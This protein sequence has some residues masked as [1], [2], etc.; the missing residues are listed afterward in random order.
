[1]ERYR[2]SVMLCGGTGCIAGGSL[3][4]K[5]ALDE[6][7]KNRGLEDEINVVLTGCNG[8]CA[9]GPVMTVY[10]EDIFYEK[11][12]VDDVPLI[13]EEHFIKG[14]PVQKLM[15]KE[16]VKK[17]TI[18]LMKDIPFFSLQVLR[19]L[20]NKGLIDAEKIDEY[21]ARDGYQAAAKA[22]TEMTPAQVVDEVK[23]SGLRG[24]GGAGFPTGLKWE[25]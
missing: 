12:K 4:L 20:R 10:P 6:E 24:R 1:M 25:L 19:A 2:A 8:F 9:E 21:I 14:R 23:R 17:Q 18:P 5:Y 15:Y 13:V 11:V 22:L 3:K 7:L 16:P